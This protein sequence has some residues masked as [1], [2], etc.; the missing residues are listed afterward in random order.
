V[1]KVLLSVLAVVFVIGLF[2]NVAA[3]AEPETVSVP[4]T[5][6]QARINPDDTYYVV[7]CIDQIE[8]FNAHKMAWKL[9]GQLYNVKT[10]WVGIPGD[11]LTE[12]VSLLESVIAKNPA[13]L[14]V[15]GW[16]EG[17]KPSINRAVEQGI[18]TMTWESDIVSSNRDT[19][20]GTAP[21][22]LGYLGGKL[23]ADYLEGKGKIAILSMPGVE[24]YDGRARGYEDAFK[25]Y[26]GIEVVAYGDT[27][28]DEAVAVQ[29]AK[30]ILT[31]HP[32]ITGFVCCDATGPMGAVTAISEAG[33][34]G[35]VQVLGLDRD[36][37]LLNNIKNGTVFGSIV[38]NDATMLTWALTDLIFGRYY[39]DALLTTNNKAAGA[40][41]LPNS[42]A[43][44]INLINKDNVDYYLAA[45]EEYVN[46][47]R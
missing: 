45:N 6:L 26:P 21:H 41:L 7:C 29:A 13:G 4:S 20:I 47:L 27:K 3:A 33:L 34:T 2:A 24:M 16:D 40:R 14:V 46:F 25:E 9:A 23:Y 15:F 35:K 10:E 43:C 30:D 17:L 39:G 18:P 28:T 11:D 12:M 1:K 36:T 32:D 5:T 22:D 8:F 44:S 31:A 37:A 42:I 19:W 38:Q